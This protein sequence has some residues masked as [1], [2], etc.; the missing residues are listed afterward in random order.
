MLCVDV[1]WT[2]H[3]EAYDSQVKN[4]P[5]LWEFYTVRQITSDC[6]FLDEIVNP[7]MFDESGDAIGEPQFWHWHFVKVEMDELAVESH[8]QTSYVE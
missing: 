8:R 3:D 6:I 1:H 2:H 7:I 4:W 5:Q